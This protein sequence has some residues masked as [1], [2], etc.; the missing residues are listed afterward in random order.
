MMCYKF[1]IICY[2]VRAQLV[3]SEITVVDLAP[4][5]YGPVREVEVSKGGQSRK[6]MLVIIMFRLAVFDIKPAYDH[7]LLIP[8]GQLDST[9]ILF[10]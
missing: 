8:D 3:F 10:A 9:E 2:Y 6:K 7:N 4:L 5:P 1:I